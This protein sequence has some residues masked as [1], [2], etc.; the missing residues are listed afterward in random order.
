MRL[1]TRVRLVLPAA[2]GLSILGG[3]LLGACGSGGSSGPSAS[4][5]RTAT[6]NDVK[7]VLATDNVSVKGTITCDGKAPGV[8]DC[9][10][11]TTDGKSI[12]ATVNAS[13]SGQNCTG[14]MVVNVGTNQ[15][16][17]LPNEK[18]S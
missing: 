12:S 5:V 17:S 2:A 16:A 18:C 15:V 4:V 14:P 9:I 13:T 7:R 6:A 1:P 3:S 8:I 10:G 11:T